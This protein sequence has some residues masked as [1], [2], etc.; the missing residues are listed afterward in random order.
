MKKLLHLLGIVLP[1]LLLSQ[2]DYNANQIVKSYDGYFRPGSNL[3]IYQNWNEQQL[4][5]IAAG[6]PSLGIDGVGV[7]AIRPA[8]RGDYLDAYGYDAQVPTFEHYYNLNLR[9]LTCIVGYPPR[10]ARDTIEHCPGHRSEMFINLYEDIWDGGAN[11]TPYNDYNHYAAYIYK[12]VDQYK[13]YV[14]FWEIWNEPG[15]DFTGAKGWLPPGPNFPGNW[16]D[17]NPDPCDNI[18]R[19]PIYQYVRMLRIS[20]EVIKTL[21]PD[22]FVA[23]AGVGFP[24]F[25]DAVLRNTDNPVDGSPTDEYPLGGGAYFDV[26]GFHSYPHFDGS[27]RYWSN[28]IQ[29]FIHTR[30][31]DAAADG[32]LRRQ[33][34]YRT[35]LENYGYDGDTYPAKNWII[36]EINV[37]RKSFPF[38]FGHYIG[39]EEA[40]INF[41]IKAVVTAMQ[42][43]IHQ[44]H[45]YNLGEEEH[46]NEADYEFDL[47]GLYKKLAG[48]TFNEQ[49][50]NQE[51]IAYKTASDLLFETFPERDVTTSLQLPEGVRGGAFVGEDGEPIYVLWAKTSIDSSEVAF[52]KYSFPTELDLQDMELK[53]WDYSAIGEI[54]IINSQ[55]IE[56]DATPI[57]LTKAKAN[58]NRPPT[59][60]FVAKTPKGCAPFEVEFTDV[61]SKSV[62][63]WSWTF[64]GADI[65]KSTLQNPTVIYEQAGEYLVSLKVTNNTGTDSIAQQAYITIGTDPVADFSYEVMD[66][67]TVVFTNQSEGAETYLWG[68]G[69]GN[70]SS[71]INPTYHFTDGTYDVVLQ[72]TNFCNT[73]TTFEPITIV[74]QPEAAF[75]VKSVTGCV[76]FD[77][78]FENQSSSNATSYQ[79]S[80]P[81]ADQTTSDMASPVVTYNEPGFY[82]VQLIVSNAAGNDTIQQTAYIVAESTPIVS[83]EPN[84]FGR[85]VS[86]NT[87]V[88]GADS[89]LWDFGDS[90]TSR[91][92]TPTHTYESD[93]DFIISLK[94][95]NHCGEVEVMEAIQILTPP[96]SAF[97]ANVVN[98]CQ[99]LE[100]SFVDQ[101]SANAK[102][103][104]WLMP[105]AT[106]DTSNLQNPTVTYEMPGTYSV[107]LQVTNGAGMHTTLESSFIV[108]EPRPIADFSFDLAD[109]TV[110]IT[111]NSELA[112]SYSWD[113]GDGFTSDLEAPIHKYEE[114]GEYIIQLIATNECGPDTLEQLVSITMPTSTDLADI[115]EEFQLSPN[116]NNGSFLLIMKGEARDE[117]NFKLIDILGRVVHEEPIDFKSEYFRKMFVMEGLA[118][119]TYLVQ[120]RSE[121]EVLY[122]KVV[123]ED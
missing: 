123:V 104:Y 99:P 86:F 87:T 117:M 100:V 22:A 105:G 14:K 74:T 103:W 51:G 26:M 88:N 10:W 75:N 55:F 57:F 76:P 34:E 121:G 28:E 49:E 89:L 45:V 81:G 71:E 94:A 68:F 83:F 118:T 66:D 8:L 7:R 82:D 3:G 54:S 109:S 32:I 6:D 72:A 52:A 12:V 77:V 63:G 37:P 67:S 115:L 113:F 13:K 5:S 18:L 43:D 85:M 44:M 30:H 58:N 53:K 97:T 4:A 16:W 24:S 106:P 56:L 40:Q 112:E 35:V 20:Y 60:G 95:F 69:D 107:V 116:P 90:V 98:G 59:A 36:T 42:N 15:F 92:S 73:I 39:S 23:V 27:L 102:E 17:N 31:S 78:S 110:T 2:V 93:G 38:V 47:M 46:F 84:V 25:L 91:E 119:G 120:L 65:E 62:Q 80:F 41:M 29:G 79:W 1:S 9:D 48:T 101:S 122:R 19:A 108:V 96:V 70:I 50:I 33:G 114:G 64:E 61:S 11:G 21:D 111:N